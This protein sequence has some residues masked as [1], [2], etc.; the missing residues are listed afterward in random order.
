ML[1]ATAPEPG[2]MLGAIEPDLARVWV[3]SDATRAVSLQVTSGE[4][5]SEAPVV[6]WAYPSPLEDFTTVLEAGELV[7]DTNYLWGVSID[8]ELKASGSLRSAPPRGEPGRTTL[9]FGSCTKHEVQPIFDSLAELEADL[10][11]FLGDNHYANSDDLPSLRQ[12]YRWSRERPARAAFLA[13]T[14]ILATWDDHDFTGNNTDGTEPGKQAALQAFVENW[15]NPSYG[16]PDLPGVFFRTSYRDVDFF[17]L[18]DRYY[19]GFEDSMLG[20]WQQDWL[21]AELLESSATF[22]VLVNGSQWTLQG[23]SDSWASFEAA[24]ESLF[25]RIRD[26]RID[27]VVLLSGDVHRSEF[28]SIPRV[29]AGAYDLPELTSSPLANSNSDCR[30]ES[31][32][33]ACHDAGSYFVSVELDTSAADPLL[34]ARIHDVYGEVLDEWLIS[35]SEL[36][37]P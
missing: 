24:R 4:S 28:R 30:G 6:A 2:P 7:P 8:G 13:T 17:F 27:G 15:A 22:K 31:E 12:A 1:F 25:D 5:L 36:Q 21:T 10:F 37:V 9:A 18:D 11:F 29:S 23:S 14:P 19:R 26:E 16:L 34:S 35:H 32:E 20:A 33:L 3:R